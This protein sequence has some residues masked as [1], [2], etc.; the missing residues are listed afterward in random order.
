MV[1][2][3]SIKPIQRLHFTFK[4][5]RTAITIILT[6]R[7]ERSMNGQL[8][9]QPWRTICRLHQGSLPH[10][11][12][13]YNS[14]ASQRHVR[15]LMSF[16]IIYTQLLFSVWPVVLP[17]ACLFVCLPLSVQP[18][19]SHGWPVLSPP[20]QC[21]LHFLNSSPF[22][23][24]SAPI[25]APFH[26]VSL[27]FIWFCPHHPPLPPIPASTLLFLLFLSPLSFSSFSTSSS[28]SFSLIPLLLLMPSSSVRPVSLSSIQ[29]TRIYHGTEPCN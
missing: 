17:S 5:C 3:R 11:S 26:L 12:Y 8:Q 21:S 18:H 27:L 25:L 23:P 1:S 15:R 9:V 10:Q 22:Q 14:M 29:P 24:R 13:A 20:S 28:I 6:A 2:A 16:T 7:H 4:I 19:I